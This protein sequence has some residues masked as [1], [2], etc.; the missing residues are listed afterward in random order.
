MKTQ[1]KV[2]EIRTINKINIIK[3]IINSKKILRSELADINN[4]SLMTVKHIVDELIEDE[5][6][7]ETVHEASVGRKPRSISMPE[8]YGNIVCV[9]LTSKNFFNYIIYD[10]YGK[11]VERRDKVIDN[12]Y[13]YLTNL[14]MMITQLK[15]DL[16][17]TE[18]ITL[19]IGISVPSAY[20]KDK[21]IVNHDLISGF[22]D[23]HLK[24]IFM[25][26]FNINNIRV[27]HD[28]FT[29]ARAEYNTSKVKVNSLF[30]F[31]IG[32]GI[33]GA[34]IDK[35]KP[36]RG[37]DLVAGEVGQ[38]IVDTPSGE[39]LLESVASIPNIIKEI[40][41]GKP[42]ITFLE[43]LNRYHEK[44][45]YVCKVVNNALDLV[46][47]IL[48]NIVW[49]LNPSKIIIDSSYKTFA[50]IIA[51]YTENKYLQTLKTLPIK[52]SMTVRHS[53]LNDHDTMHGCFDIVL[54]KWINEISS[55]RID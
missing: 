45:E 48:Y 43:I 1:L 49:T 8:N 23:L 27:T 7:V 51:E 14:K 13:D 6:I 5:V 4:I 46:S 28:V 41:K 55:S 52:A 40:Q 36:C 50:K 31:Y 47:K 18:K 35:G 21:D 30:Y 42:G 24:K 44:D 17:K 37:E 25:D 39:E 20:Y 2:K 26:E 15:N 10:I 3:S 12:Q 53:E 32:D 38:I 16:E 9:N 22:K 54:D 11:M 34:F 29:A 19:G 33:G